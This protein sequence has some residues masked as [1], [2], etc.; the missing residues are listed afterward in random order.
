MHDLKIQTRAWVGNEGTMT[1][2]GK[3]RVFDVKPDACLFEW[4]EE[5][6]FY[7]KSD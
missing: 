5:L 7:P 2:R 1:G 6:P 3:P 4:R